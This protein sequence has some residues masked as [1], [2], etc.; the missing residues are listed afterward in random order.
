MDLLVW[1][2]FRVFW[3]CVPLV[4]MKG[5]DPVW[6]GRKF[7]EKEGMWIWITTH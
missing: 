2:Y 3:A 1:R 6:K 7:C 5:E 4:V